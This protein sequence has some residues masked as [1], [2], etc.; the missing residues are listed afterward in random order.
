MATKRIL[1]NSPIINEL[2]F[3]YLYNLMPEQRSKF[4]PKELRA[5]KSAKKAR[6]FVE[7]STIDE[8]LLILAKLG[9]GFSFILHDSNKLTSRE[10]KERYNRYKDM[11]RD[12]LVQELSEERFVVLTD[13]VLVNYL[14]VMGN[15]THSDVYLLNLDFHK[16]GQSI[17][18][19]KP[20][21]APSVP[22][23]SES[24]EYATIINRLS[25]NVAME[26]K[27]IKGVSELADIDV[28][29]LM[30][31]YDNQKKYV[32][33]GVIEHHFGG[34]YK[35]MVIASAIKRLSEKLNIERNPV[36]S[37]VQEYQITSLGISAI[38]DFHKRNL[39]LTV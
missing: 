9:V 1:T 29:L 23:I 30:F 12:K 31:F 26:L 7:K 28:L 37:T 18:K 39:K 3:D 27:V 38:M 8:K 4:S 6:E 24:L 20:E 36:Y 17:N 35:K 32:S 33:R 11:S 22:R 13:R 5:I 14:N 25:L 10:I 2:V 21:A 16:V 19:W 34:I 15:L